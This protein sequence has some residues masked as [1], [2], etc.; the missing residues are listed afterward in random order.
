MTVFER[1]MGGLAKTS[2]LFGLPIEVVPQYRVD[3]FMIGSGQT[4]GSGV[5]VYSE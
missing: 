3:D 4:H 2:G 1:S 5:F